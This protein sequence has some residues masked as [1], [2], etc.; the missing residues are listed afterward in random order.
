[1][2]GVTEVTEEAVAEWVQ[3]DADDTTVKKYTQSCTVELME[4]HYVINIQ[5]QCSGY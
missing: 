2:T 1:M 3:Q 4:K 5:H